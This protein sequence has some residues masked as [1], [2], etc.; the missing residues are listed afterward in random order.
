MTES[1]KWVIGSVGVVGIL[2]VLVMLFSPSGG[3]SGLS[4]Q[5]KKVSIMNRKHIDKGVNFKNYNSNPPTS[6]PHW[7]NQAGWGVYSK[8]LPDEQLVHNLEHGGI[9]ISYKPKKVSSS[10]LDQMKN[11]AQK[12]TNAVI[13]TPRSKNDSPIAVASWGRLMKLKKFQRK[14]VEKFIKANI[15]NSPEKMA[16]L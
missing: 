15:N 7:T 6:G 14:K 8:P 16:Q 13:L 2:I 5:G 9:W 4:L 1:E 3:G 10:T 12:Y 11:L